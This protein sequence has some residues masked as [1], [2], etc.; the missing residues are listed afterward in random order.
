[1]PE[2]QRILLTAR[3][4]A[5]ALA[6]SER[7]LA[8]LTTSGLVPVVRFPGMRAVRYSADAIREAM[9]RLQD[10]GRGAEVSDG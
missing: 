5:G 10:N 3:E 6:V 7:T 2:V 4:A 8:R 1:V 9:S